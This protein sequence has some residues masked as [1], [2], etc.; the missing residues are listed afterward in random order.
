MHLTFPA[1]Q[2]PIPS[3]A[4]PNKQPARTNAQ[5]KPVD[6]VVFSGKKRKAEDEPSDTD[7]VSQKVSRTSI[8]QD[9]SSRRET[10]SEGEMTRLMAAARDEDM[11][12]LN[13]QLYMTLRSIDP[14]TFRE[15]Q[16]EQGRTALHHAIENNRLK[17]A[18]ALLDGGASKTVEDASKHTPIT[19]AAALG[20]V[21][22]LKLLCTSS[23]DCNPPLYFARPLRR[24]PL[25]TAV[26]HNQFEA[27]SFL[28]SQGALTNS[29]EANPD[30]DLAQTPLM[31]AARQNNPDMLDL[32]L[33][34]GA[35]TEFEDEAGN[36]AL[37]YAA[38]HYQWASVKKL[39]NHQANLEPAEKELQQML[40]T[41][42]DNNDVEQIRFLIQHGVRPEDAYLDDI[43]ALYEAL[44]QAT[45]TNDLKTAKL[46]LYGGLNPDA[47]TEEQTPALVLAAENKNS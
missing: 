46:L 16:D 20:N 13:R 41:A 45:R 27:A 6:Q 8:E 5:P 17:A 7:N 3:Q 9:S 47:N 23:I 28:L 35:D 42:C 24:H 1:F 36:T 26:Q 15:Q 22:A 4:Q 14:H 31:V 10:E 40:V 43:P 12:T 38:R 18:K 29:L 32:L 37:T 2:P 34:H 33:S 44:Q 30:Q 19:R 39:L 21:E 11:E 25:N